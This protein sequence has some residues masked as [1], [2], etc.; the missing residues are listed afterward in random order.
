S[1]MQKLFTICRAVQ[2]A[3]C[4][5]SLIIVTT[6]AQH[7]G[8]SSELGIASA[9]P[10]RILPQARVPEKELVAGMK[11]ERTLAPPA[12][13]VYT[14]QLENGGA[15]IG[16]AN[17]D[18]IDLVI[19]IYGPDGRQLNRLDNPKGANGSEAIVFTALRSGI[20]KFVVR[21]SSNDAKPGKYAMRVDE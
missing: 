20:H 16:V 5:T 18:G 21:S 7:S 15:V 10:Y 12:E 3:L 1:T 4:F 8:F 11:I 14:V 19:D 2:L 9:K 6:S 13:H 17:Q